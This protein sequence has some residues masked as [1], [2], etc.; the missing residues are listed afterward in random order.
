M[1]DQAALELVTFG[2][3]HRRLRFATVRLPLVDFAR[4]DVF[5]FVPTRSG[6]FLPPVSRFH[7]SNV[8]L[9]ILPSTSSC[10]NFRRCA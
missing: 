3:L 6:N 10:A 5:A 4:S 2:R 1:F 9:E 8:W 7:S